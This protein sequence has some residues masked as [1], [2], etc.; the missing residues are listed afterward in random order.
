M[1][2]HQQGHTEWVQREPPNEMKGKPYAWD[3]LLALLVSYP[4]SADVTQLPRENSYLVL[5][6]FFEDKCNNLLGLIKLKNT[7]GIFPLGHY[8]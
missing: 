7:S 2:K 1:L 5:Q 3:A 8:G 6:R 4:A